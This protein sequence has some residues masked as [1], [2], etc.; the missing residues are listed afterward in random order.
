VRESREEGALLRSAI[1][2]REARLAGLTRQL[3]EE[4]EER[5]SLERQF[6]NAAFHDSHTG[7]P[8]RRFLANRLAAALRRARGEEAAQLAVAIFGVEGLGAAAGGLGLTVA[9]ELVSQIARRMETACPQLADCTVARLQEA[10]FA[11][12]ITGTRAAELTFAA[13]QRIEAALSEPF[14]V[15]GQTLFVS[16]RTGIAFAA[17]GYAHPDD[18]LRSAHIALGQAQSQRSRLCVFDPGSQEQVVSRHQLE[19]A[20]HGVAERGELRLAYQPIVALDSGRIVGFEALV[21]W[22]N[23]IEGLIPPGVFIGIAEETGL[24]GDITRWALREAVAQARAWRAHGVTDPAP[25]VSVNLSA[26]DMRQPDLAPFVRKLIAESGMEPGA[27]RLEVT[28]G[29]MIENQRE[30]IEVLKRLRDCGARILLDDFGTGY[31]SLSYLHALPIDYLKVDQSF[32]R[33][34]LDDPRSLGIVRAVLGLAD[35][36]DIRTVA[37]GIETREAMNMLAEMKCTY[38]QGYLFSKP[39]DAEATLRLLAS[40]AS[41]RVNA[42]SKDLAPA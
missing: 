37:E 25:Y 26:H 39:V 41:L 11:L 33:R 12:A 29:S 8:N 22:Q 19:T 42:G 2:E 9:D 5:R 4:V 30:T 36:M 28:E 32:V 10:Q 20:L 3:T 14:Q 34:M 27:L 35:A 18:I 17:S 38:G 6:D 31:S 40:P 16:V 23:P 7:L 1:A 13:V 21:R 24:I 15:A